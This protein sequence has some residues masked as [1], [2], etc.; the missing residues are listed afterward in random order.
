MTSYLLC[1]RETVD[2]L[3]LPLVFLFIFSFFCQTCP[4]LNRYLWFW[5]PLK[6]AD[7]GGSVQLFPSY[8][9]CKN[10]YKNW[11]FHFHKTYDYQIWQ[12]GTSRGVDSNEN[13]QPRAGDIIV[14]RSPDKLKLLYLYILPHG[15]IY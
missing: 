14:S 12:A 11:Y 1:L 5:K 2:S 15:N 3:Q 7:R 13:S 4:R 10:W 9:S 8:S 6:M